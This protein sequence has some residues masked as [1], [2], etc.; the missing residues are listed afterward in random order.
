MDHLD[1]T[2]LSSNAYRLSYTTGAPQLFW[3]QCVPHSFHRD[4]G[5]T[6][7]PGI[8]DLLTPVATQLHRHNSP[9]SRQI[10]PAHS[11]TYKMLLAQPLSFEND[12]FSWGG[13]PPSPLAF[14]VQ[15]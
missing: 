13:V 15:T 4:G 14:D 5:C 6:P 1:S 8:Q 7:S 2:P 12:P 9:N 10:S 3:N 11:T